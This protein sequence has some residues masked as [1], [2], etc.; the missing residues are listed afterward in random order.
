MQNQTYYKH[1]KFTPCASVSFNKQL[2]LSS[3]HSASV[4]LA[5]W[6]ITLL[7]IL[8]DSQHMPF[9]FETQDRLATNG[10]TSCTSSFVLQNELCS[11]DVKYHVFP[12]SLSVG[13][14]GRD[15]PS[16]FSLWILAFFGK[17]QYTFIFYVVLESCKP[18]SKLQSKLSPEGFS[19][20]RSERWDALFFQA[21]RA[22]T[23]YL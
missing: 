5:W 6:L 15:V 1:F 20:C 17:C 18:P 9:S 23:I 14:G 7:H 16:S 2:C 10:V 12:F 11:T 19:K 21:E 22:C 4:F 3:L 13:E 8:K